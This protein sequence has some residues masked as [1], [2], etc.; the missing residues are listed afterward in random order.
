M[1]G[2]LKYYIQCRR[3]SVFSATSY[4][5]L[6]QKVEKEKNFGNI[7]SKTVIIHLTFATECIHPF[8]NLMAKPG[9]YNYM[10][11]SGLQG[12]AAL[13]IVLLLFIK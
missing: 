6:S 4:L 8:L 3:I 5:K 13:R 9:M 10:G 2:H 11:V 12:H 1:K 7:I